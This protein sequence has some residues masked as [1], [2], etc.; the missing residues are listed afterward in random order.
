[1]SNVIFFAGLT[2]ALIPGTSLPLGSNMAWRR[3]SARGDTLFRLDFETF[4]RIQRRNGY[5][6]STQRESGRQAG[7]DDQPAVGGLPYC[8]TSKTGSS[9]RMAS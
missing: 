3:R 4:G 6:H 8:A 7:D 5:D 1:V 9:S 2:P